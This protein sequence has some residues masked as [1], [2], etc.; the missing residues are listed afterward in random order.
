MSV[1]TSHLQNAKL[2]EKLLLGKK[3]NIFGSRDKVKFNLP[4]LPISL[5]TN[6]QKE[7]V[8]FFRDDIHFPF[9]KL[10]MYFLKLYIMLIKSGELVFSH[11]VPSVSVIFKDDLFS[12]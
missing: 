8:R 3:K 7:S 10:C 12:I 2:I 11:Q 5:I 9:I 6:F 4:C 1:L